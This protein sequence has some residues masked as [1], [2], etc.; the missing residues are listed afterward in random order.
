MPN[1]QFNQASFSDE[2]SQKKSAGIITL[3]S[4]FTTLFFI[5]SIPWGNAVWDGLSRVF[6]L[7]AFGA[8]GLAFISGGSRGRFNI[9]HLIVAILG[10][11]LIISL[12]WSPDF[13]RGKFLLNTILQL[14]LLTVLVTLN[15]GDSKKNILLAYHSYVLGNIVGSGIIIYNYLNGIESIYYQRYAI[16]TLDIDGQSIMLT[17]A[18][19]MAAY[20]TTQYQKK[21]IKFFYVISIPT[22]VFSVFLTGTR[23]AAIVGVIGILYWLMTYRNASLRVKSAFFIIFVASMIV[24]VSLAPQESLDRIMSSGQ[25]ISSGTLNN[26]TVIWG[27]SL[28]QWKLSPF[29]GNGIGSLEYILNTKHVQYDSAHSAYIHILTE[30]GVIGLGLYL[31]MILAIFYYSFSAPFSEM[32]FFMALLLT[33]LVSQIT[34]HTHLSKET[35][36]AFTMLALHANLI[37]KPKIH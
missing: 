15:M 14:M 31:L 36:F 10:A 17:L 4:L 27:A 21:W 26:R 25:S 29:I 11:W 7:F 24:A 23:T 33:I 32:I 34:Q 16:P 3:V 12:I 13:E 30:N 28:E 18:I 19:P 20:L 22:I 8:A 37:S 2:I 1:S 9:F 6:G 35:W 5:F